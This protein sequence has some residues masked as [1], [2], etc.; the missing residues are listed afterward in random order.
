ME[1][2]LK[3]IHGGTSGSYHGAWDYI[4]ANGPKELVGE[5]ITG[6]K[7]GKYIQEVFSEHNQTYLFDYM[8]ATTNFSHVS[9]YKY[10][11]HVI[12]TI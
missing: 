4:F 1:K 12:I 6:Y 8:I 2:A 7:R 11:N 10:I 5:F 3:F 9:G